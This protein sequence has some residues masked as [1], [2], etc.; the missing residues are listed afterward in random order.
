MEPSQLMNP[1]L[2]MQPSHI[3]DL[4]FSN[5][6]ISKL[7]NIMNSDCHLTPTNIGKY[8]LLMSSGE[9]KTLMT[10]FIQYIFEKSKVF[11]FA[12]YLWISRLC[13]KKKTIDI[14][15]TN[16]LEKRKYECVIN[17]DDTFMKLLY[18]YLFIGKNVK[19]D[20]NIIEYKVKNIKD[21]IIEKHLNNIE[22]QIDTYLIEIQNSII[23]GNNKITQEVENYTINNY[24]SNC[25]DNFT[26][27][28]DLLTPEQGQIL[29][30][31][32]DKL[33]WGETYE[34]VVNTITNGNKP[35]EKAFN[36]IVIT[37]LLCDK[38]KMFDK[39]NT[40]LYVCILA[41]ILWAKLGI[42]TISCPLST[43]KS[44]NM[45]LYDINNTYKIKSDYESVPLEYS[46]CDDIHK[47]TLKEYNIKLFSDFKNSEFGR[48][49]N[50]IKDKQVKLHCNIIHKNENES[51]SIINV[52]NI[53]DKLF[54]KLY[55][56][57]KHKN[58]NKIKINFLNLETEIVKKESDNPEYMQWNE[59]KE[60][61]SKLDKKESST[62]LLLFLSQPVPPKKIISENIKKKVVSKQLNEIYKS[63]DNLYLKENDKKKLLNS[64]SQFC[65]KKELLQNLGIQNKLNILLYGEP[66]TGKSTTIQAIASYLKRDIFYVDL[67]KAK[68]NEDL[69]MIFEY[70]NKNVSNG[71][72]VVIEDIDA[73][74]DIVL[75][76][77]RETKELTVN[78]IINSQDKS[79]TLE[80]FLNILQGTLTMED[81]V[82]I[83]TTNYL[84][85]LDPAFYRDGRFDVKIELEKCDKYQIQTIYSNMMNRKLSSELLDKIPENKFTPA[86]II[87]HVKNYIFSEDSDEIIINE[88]LQ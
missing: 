38:H 13:K 31:I 40:L 2:S 63:F 29:D 64:L 56:S 14:G 6:I 58:G 80:Y 48:N 36:Q 65:D 81:S 57:V 46:Q 43:L 27:Y 54:D 37:N 22:I 71:G 82:F 39:K 7:G 61:I 19:F 79:L 59:K 3:T 44:H 35:N 17:I 10:K 51:N 77:N 53:I 47:N 5:M 25:G 34:E 76:R 1:T 75:K 86:T 45:M 49:K 84:D 23:F 18:K 20:S 15:T 12:T 66:G 62:E 41:E 73:M 50:T 88:L 26:K 16:I 9:I 11:P 30:G 85:H 69:Q 8:I 60:I 32:K 21:I 4:F 72:I 74:T 42:S 70:V 87:Y 28:T 52:G 83:V 78:N 55:K 67:Q 24:K 68:L 33:N